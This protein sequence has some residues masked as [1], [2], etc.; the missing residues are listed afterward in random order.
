MT[1]ASNA[2]KKWQSSSGLVFFRPFLTNSLGTRPQKL[3]TK[4]SDLNTDEVKSLTPG[5]YR[6]WTKMVRT[7]HLLLLSSLK[8]AILIWRVDPRKPLPKTAKW[9][10]CSIARTN[11]IMS[12][13]K[14]TRK[15]KSRSIM[16]DSRPPKPTT[17]YPTLEPLSIVVQSN[18]TSSILGY[19][20]THPGLI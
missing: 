1:H 3:I 14:F 10:R 4:T 16:N 8:P 13:R 17:T 19:V 6:T 9:S 7:W 20:R 2:S 5:T 12:R 18:A 11:K 15:S